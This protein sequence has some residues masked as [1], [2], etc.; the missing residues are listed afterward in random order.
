MADRKRPREEERTFQPRRLWGGAGPGPQGE[1]REHVA[2]VW[3]LRRTPR[4]G[5]D[6]GEEGSQPPPQ[7]GNPKAT[8]GL[9][10]AGEGGH[11]LLP[12]HPPFPRRLP[13]GLATPPE[14]GFAR[15]SRVTHLEGLGTGVCGGEG[16]VR[17][18]S[19]SRGTQMEVT[20]QLQG[21]AREGKEKGLQGLSCGSP[22]GRGGGREGHAGLVGPLPKAR[23]EG[24]RAA[25]PHYPARASRG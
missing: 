7:T 2:G 16:G 13:R 4:D 25:R 1:L 3:R 20:L 21:G 12:A 19:S 23:R 14:S 22:S 11:F 8:G 17:R 10:V 5:N 9:A 15:P 18:F 6:S 24:E